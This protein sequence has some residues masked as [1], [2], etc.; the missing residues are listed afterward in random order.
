MKSKM[1]PAFLPAEYWPRLEALRETLAALEPSIG[2]LTI[3]EQTR[4]LADIIGTDRSDL[5]D[6]R[7][8]LNATIK[9]HLDKAR[10]GV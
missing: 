6:E 9:K 7:R 4:A 5:Y 10:R 2:I 1:S 8:R 3:M